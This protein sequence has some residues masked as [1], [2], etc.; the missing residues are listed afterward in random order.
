[1]TDIDE[2]LHQITVRVSFKCTKETV[3]NS[4][5]LIVSPRDEY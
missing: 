2:G 5:Y 3:E 1:M 4:F